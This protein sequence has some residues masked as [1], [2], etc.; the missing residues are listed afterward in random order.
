MFASVKQMPGLAVDIPKLKAPIT[1][2]EGPLFVN[3]MSS[4]TSDE[5]GVAMADWPN[6]ISFG[7]RIV[8]RQKRI[9]VGDHRLHVFVV[10]QINWRVRTGNSVSPLDKTYHGGVVV[11]MISGPISACA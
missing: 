2:A 4:E 8:N 11:R 7:Q 9:E 3:S 10:R 1:M 6:R 5:P